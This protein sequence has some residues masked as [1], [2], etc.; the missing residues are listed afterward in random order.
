MQITEAL[1]AIGGRAS[2][3]RA[4]GIEV[5]VS[6]SFIKVQ[7]RPLLHWCLS[8]L[9]RAGVR[10]IVLAADS[11]LQYHEAQLVLREFEFSFEEIRFLRDEGRGVHGL[12]YHARS[13]MADQFIFECGHS[14]MAS[15]HYMRIA[16]E[17]EVE[18]VVFS[19]F[20]PDPSNLR[21]PVQLDQDGH[22]SVG[23]LEE[24][25]FAV[26]HPFVV[27]RRYAESLPKHQFGIE[28]IISHYAELHKLKYVFSELPPEFDVSEEYYRS[29]KIYDSTLPFA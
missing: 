14:V 27:D 21:Q 17:K 7:G 23:S 11:V 28:R 19:A 25:S 4:A 8:S 3:L 18:N 12:P 13:M 24:S 22:V 6:K 15:S 29:L 26:A 20:H 2:R 16:A 5:P 10:S 9:Y 1:V